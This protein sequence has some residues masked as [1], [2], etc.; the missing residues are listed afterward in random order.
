MGQILTNT[1]AACDRQYTIY[2]C[3]T[4]NE[5][6]TSN[7]RVLRDAINRPY[8]LRVPLGIVSNLVCNYLLAMMYFISEQISF[9]IS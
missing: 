1:L 4:G 7:A 8:G 6:S 2:I 9:L 3:S 5:G